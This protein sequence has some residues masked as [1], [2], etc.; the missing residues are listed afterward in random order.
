[1]VLKGRKEVRLSRVGSDMYDGTGRIVVTVMLF[2][3][4]VISK[5]K[6]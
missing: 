1:M 3:N 5:A 4:Y 6:P 2:L